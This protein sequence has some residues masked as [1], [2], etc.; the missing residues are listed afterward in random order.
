[1]ATLHHLSWQPCITKV[2]NPAPL[3]LA[4]LHHLSWQP[5]TTQVGNPEPFELA[6]LNLG[7]DNLKSTQENGYPFRQMKKKYQ[8]DMK[9]NISKE[10]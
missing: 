3:K 10:N 5:C 4:T 7:L 8:T 1:L 9:K 6:N 2:G